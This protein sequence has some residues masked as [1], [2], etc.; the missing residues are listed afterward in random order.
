MLNHRKIRK[1]IKKLH[2]LEQIDKSEWKLRS[3]DC[4]GGG[5][6]TPPGRSR[7]CLFLIL[8]KKKYLENG[9]LENSFLLTINLTKKYFKLTHFIISYTSPSEFQDQ[10]VYFQDVR[11]DRIWKGRPLK[12][13]Y[14]DEAEIFVKKNDWERFLENILIFMKRFK[15]IFLFE[16]FWAKS[17]EMEK[18]DLLVNEYFTRKEI[19]FLD[20]QCI[21]QSN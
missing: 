16:V 1:Y 8:Q 18:T 3:S 4:F 6:R 13:R 19:L 15:G 7:R 2:S 14:F 9:T 11:L 12:K 17:Y 5:L 20:I 21:Q 10:W